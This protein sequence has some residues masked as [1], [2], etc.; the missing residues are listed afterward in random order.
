MKATMPLHES[1]AA[2]PQDNAGGV[3]W[4]QDLPSPS[5]R[6]EVP[7]QKVDV[8]IVGSGY[9]GLNAALVTARAGRSTLVLDANDVGWG[10]ST[11][12]GGQI[13]TSIKP[14]FEKLS[15]RYGPERAGGIRQEGINALNWIDDFFRTE[16]INCG[17]V[18]CGRY[19]AAHTPKHYEGLVRLAEKQNKTEGADAY[20]VPRDEQHRELGSDAYF[21]GVVYPHHASLDPA[22]Y[23]R[24]LLEKAIEAGVHV[25][26]NCRVDTVEKNP[27][28]FLLQTSKG[29]VQTRDVVIATG[30]YSGPLCKWLQRR[31]IPIG[32]YIIATDP[33]PASLLDELLPTNRI[34]NDTC[35]VVYYYRTSPDRTRILF[36]G[37]VSAKETDPSV[38]GPKLHADMCRIFPQ[39]ASYGFSNSW[40]GTVGYTFDELPHIGVHD[41]M[42]YA[43]GY[44]GTGVSL[45]SYLGMRV[46][47]KI[48]GKAAGKTALDGLPFPTRPLYRGNPWFLPAAVTWYR[49]IDKIQYRQA[50]RMK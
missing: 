9:T 7:L 15:A 11:R 10:C 2:H 47:Q 31:I 44:C 35:K 43:M 1:G 5:A 8:A 26:G 25:T 37:R 46:G 6:P 32:S 41:G 19:H 45:A 40:T 29:V 16:R 3:Y 34:V 33:L 50:S 4:L 22:R 12:N 21:G 18:R 23:H 24:G 38:S 36:G 39:L 20:A 28:G 49:W 48:L 14:D 30:G 13:S 17:F 42:H 27:N